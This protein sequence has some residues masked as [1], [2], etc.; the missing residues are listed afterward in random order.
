MLVF[1][2]FDQADQQLGN[3]QNALEQMQQKLGNLGG[4][5]GGLGGGAG[6]VAGLMSYLP[7]IA[8]TWIVFFVMRR[9]AGPTLALDDF[10]INPTAR[11][12]NGTVIRIEGRKKGFLAKLF[13]LM[14]LDPSAKWTATRDSVQFE[15]AGLFGKYMIIMPIRLN[16]LLPKQ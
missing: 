16:N 2:Q 12:R 5:L 13:S 7:W 1:A 14:N 8:L 4:G 15:D 11:V 6:G 3:L 10:E 9:G